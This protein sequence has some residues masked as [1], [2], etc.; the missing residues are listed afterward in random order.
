M[1]VANTWLSWSLLRL[2]HVDVTLSAAIFLMG[3]A[4]MCLVLGIWVRVVLLP[5]PVKI[6]MP[7]EYIICESNIEAC[8]RICRWV[9]PSCMAQSAEDLI[10]LPW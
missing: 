6:C 10:V 4:I 5:T 8:I 2:L 3:A 1:P 9:P 7:R